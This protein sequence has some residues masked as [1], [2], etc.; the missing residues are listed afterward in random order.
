VRLLF[1]PHM[2]VAARLEVL[3][4]LGSLLDKKQKFTQLLELIQT[5]GEKSKDGTV[6]HKVHVLLWNLNLNDAVPLEL[7]DRTIKLQATLLAQEAKR[8][9]KAA[10]QIG[11]IAKTPTVSQIAQGGV[12]SL[13][14]GPTP[15]PIG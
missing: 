13:P 12:Y 6:I 4:P 8:G 11:P 9:V 3:L 5:I 14:S 7:C 10:P 1:W 2:N 15:D